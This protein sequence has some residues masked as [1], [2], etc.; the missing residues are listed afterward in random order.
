MKAVSNSSV[1]IA[2]SSIGQLSLLRHRFPE[3]V[4]IPET[5]WHEVVEAGGD[6]PGA[7]EVRASNWIQRCT[8]KDQDYVRFLRT[9]L[10]AGE[11]EAI[12]LAR[13]ERADVVLLDEKE[14]RGIARRLGLH[15][16]GTVGL[17]IWARRQELIP[18]LSA[19][20]K[21]L[22]EDGGFRLSQELCVEALRQ[23]G[24]ANT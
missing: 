12:V 19:Q 4:L 14:A 22:Q 2:L 23:V 15:V 17:L 8:V 24:E 20:L 11:A 7:K 18:N 21:A 5:V 10:D 9:E 3:G 1:L 16:L 13:Q 6:R